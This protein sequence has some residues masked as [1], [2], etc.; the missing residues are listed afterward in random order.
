MTE[1]DNNFTEKLDHATVMYVADLLRHYSFDLDGN[2]I[3]Q[4]LFH[5]L[6]NYSS[7]WV[8]LAIVEALYQGRY[9]AVSIE[10]I[11]M[12]WQRRQQ[13]LYHFNHEFERLVS[14]RLP[15][16]LV[17]S[18]SSQSIPQPNFFNTSSP[19]ERSPQFLDTLKLLSAQRRLTELNAATRE[20]NAADTQVRLPTFLE[21]SF[22]PSEVPSPKVP[23]SPETEGDREL[24]GVDGEGSEPVV[25][26]ETETLEGGREDIQAPQSESTRLPEPFGDRVVTTVKVLPPPLA[27]SGPPEPSSTPS[28]EPE[29]T[30]DSSQSP[31]K[32]EPTPVYQPKWVPSG[33]SKDPIDQFTPASESPDFCSKLK[34]VA[35]PPSEVPQPS[36]SQVAEQPPEPIA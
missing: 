7:V 14:H 23:A 35:Q 15:R 17:S 33:G 31:P 21:Q 22:Q 26:Q 32:R 1:Q 3:E 19:L 34:A 2:T 25:P 11:L 36:D 8:R 30:S 16:N 20:R 24:P 5:W 4:L 10:Q 6:A 27:A 29:G 13:P 18:I 28:A 9:K 12:F